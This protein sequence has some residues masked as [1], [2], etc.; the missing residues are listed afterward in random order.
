MIATPRAE[1]VEVGR[2]YAIR[3]QEFSCGTIGGDVA[4]AGGVSDFVRRLRQRLLGRVCVPPFAGA[5]FCGGEEY[6]EEYP[7]VEIS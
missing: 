3:D 1:G 5:E 7:A 2:L 4:G 6:L